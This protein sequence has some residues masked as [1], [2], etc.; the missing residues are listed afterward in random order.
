MDFLEMILTTLKNKIQKLNYSEERIFIR[1]YS[2]SEAIKGEI[3]KRI[4]EYSGRGWDFEQ[5]L[6]KGAFLY[7][8]FKK[9]S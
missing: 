8:T 2:T 4:D 7:V 1:A 5:I 3:R 6:S 9:E